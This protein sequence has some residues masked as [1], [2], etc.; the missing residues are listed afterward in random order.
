VAYRVVFTPEARAQL[1]S[2]YS[3]IAGEAGPT[4]AL[5]FTT[6]I[7]DYCENLTMFP[8]RATRR[9]DL[10]PGIRTIGFRRRVTVAY[11]VDGETITII[12]I[13]YGG[14]DVDDALRHDADE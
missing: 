5:G 10:R 14:Q 1:I 3:Y 6:A 12:G 11:D 4:V 8:N 9:D 2:I 7:V 13:F